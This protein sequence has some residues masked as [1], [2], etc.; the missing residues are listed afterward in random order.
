MAPLGLSACSNDV[1]TYQM[2]K[3]KWI[4]IKND[5]DRLDS[6][7]EFIDSF[8]CANAADVSLELACD[9]IYSAYVNDELVA[10]AQCS[11]FP[12]YKLYDNIDISN[13]CKTGQTNKVKICVWHA[14]GE[15]VSVYQHD[16]AGVIYQVKQQNEILAFSSQNT[17]S[18]KMTEYANGFRK[19]ITPQMGYSFKFDA[20]AKNDKYLNSI[21]VN[22]TKDLH[23]REI[24]Q[25]VLGSLVE[26]K[27]VKETSNSIIYD[28]GEETA[29]FLSFDLTTQS[30][31]LT[32][33]YGEHLA[34]G[35]VRRHI[36]NRD[37]SVLYYAKDGRNV[38]TNPF[39]RLAGRYLELFYKGQ[40]PAVSKI[41]ILPVMYPAK[42]KEFKLQ[43]PGLQ[44][45]YNASVKTLQSCMHEHYE[46][47]PW[48]E[49]ALYAMDG[50][51]QML[52]GYYA[53]DGHEYQRHNLILL[54]KSLR[55]DGLLEICAPSDTKKPIVFFSLCF[56]LAVCEY[57]EHTGDESILKIVVPTIEKILS[58]ITK[59]IKDDL[60]MA[61]EDPPFWNF[62]EWTEDSDGM[63][64]NATCYL[65]MNAMY[66]YIHDMYK[67]LSGK[68]FYDTNKI[69]EATK[70]K[71]FDG[72][73]YVL[74]DQSK[75]DSQ[76]GNAFL[77]LAS[78]EGQEMVNKI[79]E[80]I[81][82]CW[83]KEEGSMIKASLSMK[84]FVY[85]ALLKY[86]DKFSDVVL[87][88]IRYTFLKMINDKHF[89]GTFWE[90]EEGQSAF[91]DAGSLCHGWSAIAAYYLPKYYSNK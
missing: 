48:R 67:E 63:D 21:E 36:D 78:I 69:R 52:C 28:L 12:N 3:A 88:D 75:R 85:D 76:L 34:D 6:Y 60:I 5:A 51:N 57:V 1:C 71:F 35:N 53:F 83:A 64:A 29:G 70:K 2:S 58:T 7:G 32:I 40:K 41:G 87:Q 91:G 61:F 44:K 24:S 86:E 4:W 38:Y 79:A 17:Q 42:V 81:K 37:F 54:S 14:P 27:P 90:T 65:M 23:K 43:D 68:S 59:N 80:D 20:T 31:N 11:D 73:K 46:D 10:F 50:R 19:P 39:R 8:D 72:N 45:I 74:N 62:F 55:E 47:C 22:K 18:H 56:I 15:D 82:T 49:Q 26:A 77:V 16:E 30:Q 13:Y 66:C 33:A 89:S 25:L 84:A 9:G